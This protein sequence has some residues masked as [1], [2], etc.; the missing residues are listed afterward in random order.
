M[1]RTIATASLQAIFQA[2]P[3]K[4]KGD[5]HP[6]LSP[7]LLAAMLP[8]MVP[9]P[10]MRPFMS[11]LLTGFDVS[12]T[13]TPDTSHAVLVLDRNAAPI[14]PRIVWLEDRQKELI[15]TLFHKTVFGSWIDKQLVDELA[16]VTQEIEWEREALVPKS[17]MACGVNESGCGCAF[18]GN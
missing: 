9:Q 15:G 11:P 17:L 2:F 18:G 10:A 13:P 3:N 8:F 16:L 6:M 1:V 4:G 5:P 7:A 12:T 14:K